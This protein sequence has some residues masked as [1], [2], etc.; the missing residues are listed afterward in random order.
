M[1]PAVTVGDPSASATSASADG[2]RIDLSL[3]QSARSAS[4]ASATAS[5]V[6]SAAP[7]TA[8]ADLDQFLSGVLERIR[9]V[10]T[11]GGTGLEARL[12]HPDLGSVRLVVSGQQGDVV[13]AELI[14]SDR[15]SAD[16][17]SRALDRASIGHGLA[18]IDL[19]IRAES[20]ASSAGG[21]GSHDRS[22][23]N[24]PGDG[25]SSGE[26]AP[27][28]RAPDGRAFDSGQGGGTDRGLGG[29]S[30]TAGDAPGAKRTA[31]SG[32]GTTPLRS[33]GPDAPSRPGRGIDLRA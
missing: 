23:R 8:P 30:T 9:T 17:L 28:G 16:A 22:D 11:N 33:I 25:R 31:P 13:R 3:L 10:S 14:A 6:S 26:R 29:L 4:G 7:A 12:Q 2:P 5:S 15:A 20:A 1:S 32:P 19:R 27:D 24:A 21:F 18:G